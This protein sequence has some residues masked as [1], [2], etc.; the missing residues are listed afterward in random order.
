MKNLGQYIERINTSGNPDEAFDKFRLIM[1]GYGYE[2]IAYSLVTDHPSLGLPRQHGLAT[3]YPEDWMRFYKEKNYSEVDPVTQTI[4]TSRKPFFWS[5]VVNDP[6][7]ATSS[8]RLMREAEDSGVT[9]GIGISL[10]GQ[11]NE[12]V[13]VGLA[14]KHALKENDYAL[15]SGAYLLSVYFH[16]TYRAMLQKPL[17][18][19]LSVRETEILNWAAE[20]KTDE[21]IATILGISGNTVRFHWKNVFT[22]LGANG[23]IY[24]ITKAI[25]LNLINPVF[26]GNPYQN[27]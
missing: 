4:L 24:A 7:I 13:G 26:V 17:K 10:C 12:L 23:R 2:R 8:L 11:G 27:R 25:R 19:K 6:E 1:E 5:D 22:K 21:D 18:V 3:S 20:G 14:R 15:L 9:D 16:E